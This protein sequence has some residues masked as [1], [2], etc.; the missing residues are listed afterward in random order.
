MGI[1]NHKF[2]DMLKFTFYGMLLSGRLK[3]QQ[4]LYAIQPSISIN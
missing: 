4:T 2:G 1:Y 3:M